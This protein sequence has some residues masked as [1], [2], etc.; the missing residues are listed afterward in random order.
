MAYKL[1]DPYVVNGKTVGIVYEVDADGMHGKAF[2]LTVD[3]MNERVFF[4]EAGWLEPDFVAGIAENALPLSMTDG[5]DN[6]ERMKNE[7]GW[8]EKF[9]LLKWVEDLGDEPGQRSSSS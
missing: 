7:P 2:S 6:C 4:A 9:Q 3:N 8:S 5:Q 1:G